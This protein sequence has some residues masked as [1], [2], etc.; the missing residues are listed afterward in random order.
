MTLS[1]IKGFLQ[2]PKQTVYTLI[3]YSMLLG[4]LFLAIPVS[5]QTLVNMV[6]TTL[7]VRP[8][9]SLITV[10][11]ILLLASFLVRMAQVRLVENI[12]RKLFV[13]FV[14]K[15]IP[16]L[17]NLKFSEFNTLNIREKLNRITEIK[18]VQKSLATIFIVLLDIFLQTLFC[19]IVLAFYHPLFLLFDI[20]LISCIFVSIFVPLRSAFN[21]GIKESTSIY[22]ILSWFEER[23]SEFTSFNQRPVAKSIEHVDNKV[24]KYLESRSKLFDVVF[25]QHIYI[26]FTYVFLNIVLMSM[27]S[28][29]IIVGQLSIGQLIGAELLVNI[30]LLGLLKFSH[31]L[32][33]GY[34]FLVGIR[35]ML[36]L[37][38]ISAPN[39]I[40]S[41]NRSLLNVS[42]I[43]EFGINISESETYNFIFADS[44]FSRIQLPTNNA[45]SVLHA[46]FENDSD[47]I[48]Q[49]NGI[50][51]NNYNRCSMVDSIGFVSGL[52]VLS[53]TVLDNLY[54]G[55]MTNDKMNHLNILLEL[56]EITFL[57][58]YFDL[59][60]DSQRIKYNLL[61]DAL[62]VLKI[63]II[64]SVMRDVKLLVII[65]SCDF[66]NSSK[67]L[68]ID[69]ALQKIGVPTIVIGLR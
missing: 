49:I 35:K 29:L 68:A 33:D 12:Q 11:T 57:D 63:N 65:D 40:T 21:A 66:G 60:I 44:I 15:L 26:G 7:S 54:D 47:G 4:L 10:L 20:L 24:C 16:T 13:D 45:Q 23:S 2:I 38:E 52:E 55:E 31:Y 62:L 48:L 6:G 32:D 56:F 59:Y 3:V 25:I 37:L 27:G 39:E 64:R 34:G 18:V 46:F 42:D 69:K 53:G 14:F 1:Q 36:D 58:N 17:Y 43:D 5:V 30:V 19:V 61:F 50:K 51:I 22:D 8:A 67:G 41:Q 28:Y 9:V